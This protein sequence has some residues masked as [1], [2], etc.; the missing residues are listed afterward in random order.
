MWNVHR[1]KIQLGIDHV[2]A[3]EILLF[4]YGLFFNFKIKCIALL[5]VGLLLISM[6]RYSHDFVNVLINYAV[7]ITQVRSGQVFA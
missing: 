4:L 6:Y 2:F 1:V 7:S 5:H 3:V